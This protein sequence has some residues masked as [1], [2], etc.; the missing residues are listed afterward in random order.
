MSDLSNPLPQIEAAQSQKEVTANALFAAL[1][2]AAVFGRNDETSNLLTWGYFG[3][4]YRGIAI[5]HGTLSLTASQ[6]N[7]YIVAAKATGVVSFATNTTNWNDDTNY[8]RLY[9]VTTSRHRG[10]RL[11]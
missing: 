10:D 1:S 8:D 6:A 4:R 11:G 9:W 7:I 3:G 5:A 2:P